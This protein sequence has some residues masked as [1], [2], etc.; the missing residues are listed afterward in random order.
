[1]IPLGDPPLQPLASGKKVISALLM[2]GRLVWA[3]PRLRAGR[4]ESRDQ[5]SIIGHPKQTHQVNNV[6]SGDLRTRTA[7]VSR[8]PDDAFVKMGRQLNAYL[9]THECEI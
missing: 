6:T 7:D 2:S 3:S 8:I 5:S 1:M 9:K 4:F